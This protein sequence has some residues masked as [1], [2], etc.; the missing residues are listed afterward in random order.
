MTKF[1]RIVLSALTGAIV[2]GAT[3]GIVWSAKAPATVTRHTSM[4][5]GGR[6][7]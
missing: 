2:C 4:I 7:T 3:T 6:W 5:V 1:H